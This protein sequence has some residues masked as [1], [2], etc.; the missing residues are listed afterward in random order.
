MG[1]F[2]EGN[3]PFGHPKNSP[4]H[5]PPIVE[6]KPFKMADFAARFERLGLTGRKQELAA[7][8]KAGDKPKGVPRKIGKTLVYPVPHFG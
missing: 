6:G 1:G 8:N 2:P 3:C 5:K 4:L 7:M